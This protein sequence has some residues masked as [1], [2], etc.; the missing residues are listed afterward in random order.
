ML[1]F[2]FWNLDVIVELEQ[3]DPPGRLIV[4]LLTVALF[5]LIKNSYIRIWYWVKR[6]KEINVIKELREKNNAS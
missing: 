6:G 1:S 2:S 3:W 5:F 4:F